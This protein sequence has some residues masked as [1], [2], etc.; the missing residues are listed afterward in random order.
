[1]ICLI[2]KGEEGGAI[3]YIKVP[4]LPE[5]SAMYW[6]VLEMLKFPHAWNIIDDDDKF[7][8]RLLLCNKLHLHQAWDTPCTRGPI[9][10]Y[11]GKFGIGSSAKDTI[12]GKFDPNVAHNLPEDSHPPDWR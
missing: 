7:M 11:I 5:N 8:S 6:S 12:K 9:K 1:M 3:S 2:A 10:D 4:A